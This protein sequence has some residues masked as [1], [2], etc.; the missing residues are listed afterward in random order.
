[1]NAIRESE[2][3]DDVGL[4]TEAAPLRENTMHGARTR[5]EVLKGLTEGPWAP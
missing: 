3:L 4:P 2:Y 1:M 5:R